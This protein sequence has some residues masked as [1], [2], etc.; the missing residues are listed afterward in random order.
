MGQWVD[1]SERLQMNLA[2]VKKCLS[3]AGVEPWL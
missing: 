2:L 1:Y 3:D